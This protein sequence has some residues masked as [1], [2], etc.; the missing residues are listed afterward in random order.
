MAENIHL[1]GES[2]NKVGKRLR[3]RIILFSVAALLPVM[4]TMGMVSVATS[5]VTMLS[6]VNSAVAQIEE[7]A[8]CQED[9][10]E[11]ETTS[12]STATD[13][14]QTFTDKYGEM[15]YQTG[16]K[17][18]L[19]YEAILGQAALES[20]W[21][22]SVLAAKHHNFFG[23][24][25]T[26]SQ[27][28]VTM[29]TAECD[30][31]GCYSTSATFASWDNDQEGFDGYGQFIHDNERY[32]EALEFRADPKGYIEALKAAGYAT[33]PNYI[34]SVWGVTEQFIQYIRSSKKWPESNAMEF[35][36]ASDEEVS[37]SFSSTEDD[38]G[39]TAVCKIESSSASYGSVG[40]APAEAN[41]FDWMC[42]TNQRVCVDGDTGVF[43]PHIELGYQ[44]VWYAWNRLAIIHGNSG[45]KWVKGDGGAIWEN[46]SG[47]SAWIVSDA[48]QAGD[49]VSG[50]G[51][52]FTDSTVGHVAVVEEVQPD[53]SGWKIRISE[54]NTNGTAS[55]TSYGSRWLTKDT[56][57]DVHFFRNK[58]WN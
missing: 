26:G 47:K 7:D 13:T 46:M 57:G 10:S 28:S 6:A 42:S 1:D 9:D 8:A 12:S 3:N 14:A 52:L 44:C 32:S 33:D 19:P 15:A 39:E 16:K 31:S 43:Y 40:G 45:W 30:A 54:G 34:S 37:S 2:R 49:G 5:S 25:A 41:S 51:G 4:L 20:S 55:F 36:I 53:S 27:K 21:G 38:D 35:D 17:Y 23:I 22:K 58:K 18:G 11:E 24:K 48:P 56:A 29:A 50:S